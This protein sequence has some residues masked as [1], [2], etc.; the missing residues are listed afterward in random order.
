MFFKDLSKRY[1]MVPTLQEI[2]VLN[3]GRH[4]IFFKYNYLPQEKYT[5]DS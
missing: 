2:K 1:I 3:K 4:P 5:I